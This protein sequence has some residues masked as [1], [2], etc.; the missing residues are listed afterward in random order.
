MNRLMW[1]EFIFVFLL[2]FL[3]YES[4]ILNDDDDDEDFSV[5]SLEDRNI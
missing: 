2:E 5:D 1:R 4:I 3:S